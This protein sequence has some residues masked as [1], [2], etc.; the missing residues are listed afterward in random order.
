MIHNLA[1]NVSSMKVV[2]EE[3]NQTIRKASGCLEA[4]LA[5]RS[6]R[7]QFEECRNSLDQVRGILK[8]LEIP[9]A[10]KLSVEMIELMD[11]ILA[12]ENPS[13]FALSAISQAFVALPCYLE[14]TAAQGKALT[15]LLSPYINEVRAAKRQELVPESSFGTFK[16][17]NERKAMPQQQAAPISED[18]KALS[19][20]LR[21]MYHVGL[22][23]IIRE[24]NTGLKIEIMQRAMQRLLAASGNTPLA[25]LWWLT[26]AV[27]EGFAEEKLSLGM[28]RKRLLSSIDKY[29]KAVVAGGEDALQAEVPQALRKELLFLVDLSHA[30]GPLTQ[31]VRETYE[32]KGE[33]SD[34]AIRKEKN[35]MQGPNSETIASMVTVLKEELLGAKEVLEIAS[36]DPGGSVNEYESLDKILSKIADILSVVGLKT[37]AGILKGQIQLI[38][39]WH[40][41]EEVA[42]QKH[43]LDVADAL[44]FVESTLSGLS[45]L[46]LS[47]AAIAEASE[48]AKQQ[49]I[50]KSHLAEAELLVVKEAQAG[51]SLAKRAIS[52]FIESNY[53]AVHIS[54]VAKTLNTVRGG[55]TV[56]NVDRAAAILLSCSSFLDNAM[57]HG[58]SEE[59]IQELLETLADA[60]ISLEYYLGEVE[61]HGFADEKVLEVAEESLESLGYPVQKIA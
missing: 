40:A 33:W 37:P 20:R 59:R 6:M 35:I 44:L 21:H 9:G 42:E 3:L 13:D 27:L 30:Q 22:L 48:I 41:G 25:E 28:F 31:Q 52:S 32:L 58:F 23:G 24:D 56:L 14:Y 57:A 8:L 1:V 55:L 45:R 2:E 10:V 36:Q 34:A 47:D 17:A 49:I 51:I 54:N 29:I 4:F 7:T 18:L 5:D 60:L 19:R 38:R 43:L 15:I 53:D 16:A 12:Q 61:L 11:Q 46:D 39:Q 50:A 26:G